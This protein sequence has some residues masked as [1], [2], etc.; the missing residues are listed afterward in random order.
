ML[1]P[2]P[3]KSLSKAQE[4]MGYLREALESA[5]PE[6]AGACLFPRFEQLSMF[7]SQHPHIGYADALRI[8]ADR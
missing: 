2:R 5:T 8:F 7:A 4:D 6:V 1:A 3:P